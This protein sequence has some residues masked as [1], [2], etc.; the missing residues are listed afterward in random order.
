MKQIA[1]G[2]SD[3]SVMIENF[4]PGVRPWRFDKGHTG[5][6]YSVCMTPDGKKIISGA[7]DTTIRIWQN[8]Q[9]GASTVIREHESAVKSVALNT[10]GSL[11]VSGSEDRKLQVY[12][13]SDDEKD[14]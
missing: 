5:A 10:N 3:G 8:N 9:D 14:R 7:G 4:Q 6:V 1:Y 11:L 13:M 2:A 12:K